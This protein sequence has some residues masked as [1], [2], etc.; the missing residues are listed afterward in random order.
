MVTDTESDDEDMIDNKGS[1]TQP[2]DYH[3]ST[4]DEDHMSEDN[5]SLQEQELE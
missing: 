3:D 1:L 2:A 5:A 4:L